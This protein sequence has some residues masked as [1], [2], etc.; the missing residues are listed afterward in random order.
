VQRAEP[1]PLAM[2]QDRQ[3]VTQND[4]SVTQ[5]AASLFYGSDVEIAVFPGLFCVFAWLSMTQ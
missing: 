1:L 4:A 3:L 5:N 2:T